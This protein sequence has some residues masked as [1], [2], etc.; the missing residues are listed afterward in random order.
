M[1]LFIIFLLNVLGT[2]LKN[3]K[4]VCLS[5]NAI[6]PVYI[7]TF[8]DGIVFFYAFKLT[9]TSS[10]YG[11]IIAF[12]LGKITGVFLG[13]LLEKKLALG[14]L[15]ADVYKHKLEGKCLADELRNQGYTVTTSIGYG[16]EGSER[17]L[18][19]V[20]LPRNRF[21]DFHNTLKDFGNVHMSVKKISK[22]Y[23]KVGIVGL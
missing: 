11:F 9:T 23:G 12:A 18:L 20:I 22:I 6:K 1:N 13:N 5:L 3:L 14:L 8:I 17:L 4:T 19:K 15:E 16:V 7:I 10:G 21:L 2:S